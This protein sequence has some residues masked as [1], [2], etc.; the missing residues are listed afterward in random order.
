[1]LISLLFSEYKITTGVMT[2]G[3]LVMVN[4]LIFQLSLPLNFL[5]STYRELRQAVVDMDSM[6]SLLKLKSEITVRFYSFLLF[7]EVCNQH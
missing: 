7:L 4:G 5:G 2:V 1:V 6:F 3:D